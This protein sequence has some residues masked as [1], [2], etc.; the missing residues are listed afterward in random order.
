MVIFLV[1]LHIVVSLMLM[2]VVLVQ[3]GKGADLAGAFGGGGSQTAFG[4]RGTTS[5]LHRMTTWLFVAFVV[6]SMALS[7]IQAKPGG[8]VMSGTEGEVPLPIEQEAPAM[9]TPAEAPAEAPA[10]APADAPAE[11]EAAAE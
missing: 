7:I 6:T 11:T 1:T 2:L 8:S 3:Q 10:D 9:P 5:I 4:S